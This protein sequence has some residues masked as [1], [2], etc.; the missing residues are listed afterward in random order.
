MRGNRKF[1]ETERY[2][3]ERIYFRG[4]IGRVVHTPSQKARHV[5]IYE[6]VP[7]SRKVLRFIVS[8]WS[9]HIERISQNLLVQY[10]FVIG[11]IPVGI[12]NICVE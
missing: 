12:D 8:T 11:I 9:L 6:L 7:K 10:A 3:Q 1:R 4:C 2:F 5:A